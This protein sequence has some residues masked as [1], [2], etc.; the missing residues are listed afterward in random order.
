MA[1]KIDLGFFN[2]RIYLRQKPDDPLTLVIAAGEDDESATPGKSSF[3][4]AETSP[5]QE[6]IVV[7]VL[8]KLAAAVGGKKSTI[9]VNTVGDDIILD[10]SFTPDSEHLD[11]LRSAIDDLLTSFKKFNT[12]IGD[13]L[14]PGGSDK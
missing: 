7:E 5:N 11:G 10:R 2:L 3:A 4:L 9:R 8:S 14:A 12:Q 6:A 13:H 1:K